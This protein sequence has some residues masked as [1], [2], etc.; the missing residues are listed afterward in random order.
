MGLFKFEASLSEFQDR[1]CLE[2][3][4]KPQ[5]HKA[6]NRL[7]RS[8]AVSNPEVDLGSAT[9]SIPGMEQN[10]STS[11]I[12]SWNLKKPKKPSDVSSPLG[13]QRDIFL[14]PLRENAHLASW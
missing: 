13:I 1:Q 5:S 7:V 6:T 12:G 4:T 8:S 11:L 3:Q 2:K 10:N 9:I 14:Y